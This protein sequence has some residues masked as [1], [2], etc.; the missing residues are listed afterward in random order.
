MDTLSYRM[1]RLS[2]AKA[3][4]G[5]LLATLAIGG[6]VQAANPAPASAMPRCSPYLYAAGEAFN[7]G[8]QLLGEFYLDLYVEC[9]G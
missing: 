2:R 7:E 9:L 1:P 8:Y 6:A 4:I 5:A 3:L